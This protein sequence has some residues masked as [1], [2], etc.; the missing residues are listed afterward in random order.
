MPKYMITWKLSPAVRNEAI[1]RF[2][3]NARNVPA[4]LKEIGRWHA[5][6]GGGGYS[7]VETDDPKHITNWVLQW[8]DLLPY[9]VEP[10]ITDE[11]LADSLQKNKLF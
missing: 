2:A 1:K 4:G 10:V 7:V 11:E 3:T 5:A 6:G 8:S 9:D